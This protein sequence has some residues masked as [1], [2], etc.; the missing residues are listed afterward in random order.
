MSVS[1]G[2]D[3]YVDAS[4]ERHL[5]VS[6]EM[7][8]TRISD[9]S[10]VQSVYNA[11]KQKNS[12]SAFMSISNPGFSVFILLITSIINGWFSSL[13]HLPPLLGM[14]LTGIC[15]RNIP[16]L[17]F[18]ANFNPQLNAA[19]RTFALLI[20]LTRAGLGLQP[21][22]LKQMPGTVLALSLLPNLAEASTVAVT[23]KFLLGFPWS[24]AFMLGFVLSAVST[25]VVVPSMLSFQEKRIG[26]DIPTLCLAAASVD[27]VTSISIFGIIFA[28]WT[29]QSAN[30]IDLISTPLQVIAAVVYGV[31][32]GLVFG[33]LPTSSS[34]VKSILLIFS[35]IMGLFGGA[36]LG[37][38][39]FGPL[40]TVITAFFASV[41][42][43]EDDDSQQQQ[44]EVKEF[45][46]D[47]WF[48]FEPLLFGLIGIEMDL[49]RIQAKALYQIGIVLALGAMSRFAASFFATGFARGFGTRE[50]VFIA[51]AWFSKASV[52]AALGPIV[53]SNS[54]SLSEEYV[55]FGSVILTTAVLAILVTAPAGAV[56]IELC[57]KKCLASN[58][59]HH[60]E[61]PTSSDFGIPPSPCFLLIVSIYKHK[62]S[63]MLHT[64][65]DG[66]L[67]IVVNVIVDVVVVVA[68]VIT[69]RRRRDSGMSLSLAAGRRRGASS[70]SVDGG[71]VGGVAESGERVAITDVQV[72]VRGRGAQ[73]VGAAS[74]LPLPVAAH[75]HADHAHA[76]QAQ[77][78]AQEQ[79]D[80][81][82][83][84]LHA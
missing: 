31:V 70:N 77:A 2:D 64:P 81:Q 68:A 42:W 20:I 50:R 62:R 22:T 56:A 4:F 18:T 51:I 60:P 13:V 8:N 84:G 72:A 82:L 49:S 34:R 23:A 59:D 57:A 5:F 53:L 71:R 37:F 3:T 16:H 78:D 26:K 9:S 79:E 65:D 46:A 43:Q 33:T 15:I 39:G 29:S 83:C 11:S 28:A 69:C 52:Q 35:G 75:A 66:R 6:L 73:G 74:P 36:K 48:L 58:D 19:L 67:G 41:K 30:L 76:A 21:K 7:T 45:F 63:L 44:Q 32:S 24:H 10:M 1:L 40:A 38:R 12:L 54:G 17:A 25:A 80:V 55:G 61:L 14:L 27:N 47:A